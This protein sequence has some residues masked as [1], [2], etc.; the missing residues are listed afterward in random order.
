MQAAPLPTCGEYDPLDA[1]LEELEEPGA[2]F[3]QG[4]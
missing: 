4:E 1:H 3:L 2:N